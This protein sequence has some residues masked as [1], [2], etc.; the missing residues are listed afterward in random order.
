MAQCLIRVTITMMKH[1][2]QTTQGGK[3]L[4]GLYFHIVVHQ[5]MKSR[6]ESKQSR[7]LRQDLI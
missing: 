2:D 7:D 4:F 5:Q 3:G 6:Q 1:H